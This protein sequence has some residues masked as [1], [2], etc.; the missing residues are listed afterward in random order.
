MLQLGAKGFT[1]GHVQ[2]AGSRR[3][4]ASEWE[5][6]SARIELLVPEEVARRV[7]EHLS[8]QYFTHH[9]V[10]VYVQDAT[11]LRPQKFM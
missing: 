10:I 3:V 4:R 6:P 7:L 5:G 2:G 9:A 8:Q 1:V 11:V